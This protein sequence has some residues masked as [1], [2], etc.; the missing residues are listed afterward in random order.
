MLQLHHTQTRFNSRRQ[1][2]Q[3]DGA[4]KWL[5]F[6]ITLASLIQGETA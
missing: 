6:E 1:E 4:F 3:P 2:Q 5:L